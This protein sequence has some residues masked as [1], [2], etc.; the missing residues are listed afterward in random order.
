MIIVSIKLNATRWT[1]LLA[2]LFNAKHRPQMSVGSNAS[3]EDGN[4]TELKDLIFKRP[5]ASQVPE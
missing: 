1:N 5:M 2:H 3:S 4:T